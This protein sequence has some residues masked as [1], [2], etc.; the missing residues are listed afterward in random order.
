MSMFASVAGV[1]I[2][3]LELLVSYYGIP[4]ATVRTDQP[5]PALTTGASAS[6]VVGDLTVQMAVF[7]SASFAGAQ[8]ARLVGGYGGWMKPIPAAAYDF[9]GTNITSRF[10]LNDIALQVGEK[11]SVASPTGLGS[12]F[13]V[14]AA[15]A[16][17][18]LR[19]LAGALWWIDATGVTQVGPRTNV[20]QISTP[21]QVLDFDSARGSFAIATENPSDWMPART[22]SSPTLSA[23]QTITSSAISFDRGGQLRLEVLVA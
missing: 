11:V 21:F 14:E 18:T 1:R 4:Y 10:V 5:A 9:P 2:V 3:E 17:R 13:F 16:S 22:F 8:P 6:L 20:S 23:M 19:E 7:R 15:P 12:L